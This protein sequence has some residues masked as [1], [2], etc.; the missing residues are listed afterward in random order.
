M[1]AASPQGTRMTSQPWA[2]RSIS[3][4]KRGLLSVEVASTPMR[5]LLLWRTAGFTP[6]STPTQVTSG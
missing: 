4:S 5:P 6:G 1:A 3:E 2:K